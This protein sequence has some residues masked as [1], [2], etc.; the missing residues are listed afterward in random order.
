MAIDKSGVPQDTT[1][2]AGL[3]F[4]LP[5]YHS[6]CSSRTTNLKFFLQAH[7]WEDPLSSQQAL[8]LEIN[9]S[10]YCLR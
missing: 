4:S 7:E 6:C 10:Y 1:L 3:N 5:N 2:E 8:S 9:A